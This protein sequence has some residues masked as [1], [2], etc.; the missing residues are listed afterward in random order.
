MSY[1]IFDNDTADLDYE[2]VTQL[3]GV[4]YLFR[5][6]WSDRESA[7]YM[8]LSDQDQDPIAQFVRITVGWPLLRRFRDPRLPPGM[9]I[10]IDTTGDNED[11]AVPSDL[12]A[13]VLLFYVTS[14]DEDLA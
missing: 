8:D 11:V 13:R 14:D 10:A 4:E 5:F 12:G 3:E 1:L 2:Q 6:L 9:L 7:W